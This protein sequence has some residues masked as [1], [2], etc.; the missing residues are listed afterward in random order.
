MP[1]Q[2]PGAQLDEPNLKSQPEDLEQKECQAAILRTF[3]LHSPSM[4][5]DKGFMDPHRHWNGQGMR[6]RNTA[7]PTDKLIQNEKKCK[8]TLWCRPYN[9][10]RNGW[11]EQQQFHLRTLQTFVKSSHELFT[12]SNVS[13]PIHSGDPSKSLVQTFASC[14]SKLPHD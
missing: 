9:H 11:P 14:W 8:V 10:C 5:I 7:S 12:K 2:E 3:R 1:C 13:P 4:P 6:C